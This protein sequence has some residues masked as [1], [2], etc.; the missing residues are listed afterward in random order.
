MAKPVVRVLIRT[1]L[2]LVDPEND[3]HFKT[4]IASLIQG[5]I[6]TENEIARICDCSRPTIRRWASGESAMVKGGLR[7]HVYRWLAE[8][9]D[10]A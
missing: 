6:F 4:I 3:D 5:E 8:E 10:K 7:K 1:L 9:L 2:D